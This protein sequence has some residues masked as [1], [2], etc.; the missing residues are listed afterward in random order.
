MNHQ[1]IE[2]GGALIIILENILPFLPTKANSSVQ[3]IINLAKAIF[4]KKD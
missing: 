2:I 3:L 1:T 4:G